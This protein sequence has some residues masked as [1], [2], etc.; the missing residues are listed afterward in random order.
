M[1][2]ARIRVLLVDDHAMVRE[3]LRHVL[4]DSGLVEVV[5]E[6]ADG[7]QAI[8]KTEKVRPDIVV[9]DLSMP[10]MSGLEAVGRIRAMQPETKI[11]VLTM[12]DHAQYA[13]HALQAGANG[14]V[15]KQAAAD[16]LVKAVK[17]LHEG[18]TYVTEEVAERLM[19]RYTKPRGRA[20]VLD[21]LS[22]REFEVFTLLGAGS[23]VREAAKRMGLSERTVSTY[24]ARLLEKL[25]LRNNAELIRLAME[26]GVVK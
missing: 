9:M 21:S 14:F 16:E 25:Q 6:A 15:L 2:A 10:G 23:T 24:R 4:E 22:G 8:Q 7:L 12:H 19:S 18:K 20:P 11:L 17:A 13:V 26:S 3:G 1:K 5:D